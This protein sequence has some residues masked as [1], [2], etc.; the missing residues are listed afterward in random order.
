MKIVAEIKQ[1]ITELPMCSAEQC[2]K[3]AKEAYGKFEIF[4]N[5]E[6]IKQ[7]VKIFQALGNE[8]RLKILGLLAVQ[9]LCL[10]NIVESFEGSTSTIKHHL[11][12]LEEGGFVISRKAGKFTLFKLNEDLVR[13]YLDFNEV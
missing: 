11:K 3:I 12:K 8:A 4:K 9:E 6:A 2:K 13:K 7:Q 1:S 10:C 5:E